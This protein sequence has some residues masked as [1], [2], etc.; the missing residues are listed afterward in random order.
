MIQ[1]AL[2]GKLGMAAG[3]AIVEA[4]ENRV[5]LG[6]DDDETGKINRA[7]GGGRSASRSLTG[8]VGTMTFG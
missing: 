8:A 3:E 4:L 1:G 6:N 7:I 5:Y 2:I